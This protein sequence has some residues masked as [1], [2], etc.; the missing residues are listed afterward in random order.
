[1]ANIIPEGMT[2]V[3]QLN[4][5]F[6]IVLARDGRQWILERYHDGDG[7][8]RARTACRTKHALMNVIG[9]YVENVDPLALASLSG[10][11]ANC[12][13]PPEAAAPVRNK[14]RSKKRSALVTANEM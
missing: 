7:C 14:K 11:P 8:W 10:L 1:V 4:A 5:D 2:V 6:R 3:A 13:W 9:L 12:W